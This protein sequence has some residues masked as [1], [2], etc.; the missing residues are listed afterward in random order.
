MPG[1]EGQKILKRGSQPIYQGWARKLDTMTF[2]ERPSEKSSK[3]RTAPV[4][5]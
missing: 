1:R 2:I 3:G 5:A 4:P